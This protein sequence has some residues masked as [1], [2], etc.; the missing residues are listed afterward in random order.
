MSGL[1]RNGNSEATLHETWLVIFNSRWFSLRALKC[2]EHALRFGAVKRWWPI[3]VIFLVVV[4]AGAA[5]YVDW[6]W[7]RKLSPRGGRPFLTRVELPVPSFQQSDDKWSDDELGGVAENGTLGGEGCA[8]AAAAMV[9]KFYGIDVD[10]QQLN[11]FLTATGGF[12]DQGW[13]Y[14]DRAAWFAPDRVRHVYEDLP[15]YQLID[16]NIAH[17]NPVIVRVRLASGITH[18]VVIAGKDGFD[19]LVRDPGAGSAKGLYPLRE[20]GSDIEA[21]RF[22]EPIANANSKVAARR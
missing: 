22:Y 6:T 12:T 20:L 1:C 2:R 7:K 11:W 18:F 10:P 3:V 16:S 13:L 14:W 17:G 8:V 5:V 15:S 19:Y 21:L 9:F 4:V